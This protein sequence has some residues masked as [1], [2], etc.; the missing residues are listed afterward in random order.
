MRLTNKIIKTELG[1]QGLQPKQHPIPALPQSYCRLVVVFV[2]L[3]PLDCSH[4]VVV[5][6]FQTTRQ[7]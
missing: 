5:M 1:V 7:G 2:L 6:I 3:R 4:G